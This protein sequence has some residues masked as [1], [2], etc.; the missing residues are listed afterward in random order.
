MTTANVA[1]SL[2]AKVSP[3]EESSSAVGDAVGEGVGDAV[4]DG[5]GDA[6]GDGVGDAVGEAV[7]SGDGGPGMV[8]SWLGRS[9]VVGASE[10]S[11]DNPADGGDEDASEGATDGCSEATAV[12]GDV[13]P[14]EG[15]GVAVRN[16]KHWL[17]G[18]AGGASGT[19]L[20]SHVGSMH[21]A[22]SLLAGLPAPQMYSVSGLSGFARQHVS[23]Q[24]P[25]S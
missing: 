22:K 10:G 2:N 4:G 15:S 9:K 14:P 6:V 25:P 21:C 16:S 8:G 24:S 20:S 13:G 11:E 7:G 23:Q 18:P 5:V 17:A 3:S 12:G 1:V 19:T